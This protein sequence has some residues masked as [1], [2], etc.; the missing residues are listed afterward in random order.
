MNVIRLGSHRHDEED[1]EKLKELKKMI[2][3]VFMNP[4]SMDFQPS[5]IALIAPF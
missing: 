4:I 3:Y 1:D 5:F 2:E